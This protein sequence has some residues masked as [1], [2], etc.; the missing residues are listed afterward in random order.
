MLFRSE[1]KSEVKKEA[2]KKK[3]VR[4]GDEPI[5]IEIEK[6][7]KIP[8]ENTKENAKENIK[9]KSKAHLIESKPKFVQTVPKEKT[10]T[11][12]STNS[13]NNKGNDIVFINTTSV[14]E[15]CWNC[16]KLFA[17]GK[18]YIDTTTNKVIKN[19]IIGILQ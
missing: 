15:S 7:A 16:Y 1:A 13:K 10:N 12:I 4:F 2:K 9:E 19:I 11:E 3:C 5:I 6:T 18:G 17:K 8:D 14:K